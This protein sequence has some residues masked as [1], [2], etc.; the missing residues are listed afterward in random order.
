MLR[1]QHQSTL[2][3]AR[4]DR[5]SPSSDFL[6]AYKVHLSQI[7]RL[8]TVASLISIK[9]QPLSHRIWRPTSQVLKGRP[10]RSRSW[11]AAICLSKWW[12]MVKRC[13]GLHIGRAYI[14]TAR[15]PGMWLRHV[16]QTRRATGYITL[17]VL[18]LSSLVCPCG[19]ASLHVETHPTFLNLCILWQ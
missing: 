3:N 15:S 9:G 4:S 6:S 8:A 7:P 2:V 18:L 19:K 17:D 16:A 5:R 1:T 10:W 11:S 14:A 12:A 13:P